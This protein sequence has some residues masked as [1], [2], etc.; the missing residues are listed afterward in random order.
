MHHVIA[1]ARVELA[2]IRPQPAE[3][4]LIAF[5]QTHKQPRNRP[6]QRVYRGRGGGGRPEGAPPPFTARRIAVSTF[7]SRSRHDA[8]RIPRRAT[9]A[10]SCPFGSDSRSVLNAA[11]RRRRMRF[12]LTA[13]PIFFP[14]TATTRVWPSALPPGRALARTAPETPAAPS[15]K[16]APMRSLPRRRDSLG[17]R[18]PRGRFSQALS[19]IRSVC[20]A[21]FPLL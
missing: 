15:A 14:A 19:S 2:H 9:R 3:R 8:S 7:R 5:D 6:P 21:V 17:R 4:V 10:K 18:C 11:R 12:R 13:Q 20:K 16:S 1:A